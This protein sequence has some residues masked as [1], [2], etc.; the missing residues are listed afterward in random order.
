MALVPST[1]KTALIAIFVPSMTDDTFSSGLAS[2]INTFCGTGQI[3]ASSI[4]G[5][6]SAGA[7][8]GTGTGT[9]VVNIASSDIKDLCDAMKSNPHQNPDGSWDPGLGE[10]DDYLAEQLAAI[11]DDACTN[12]QFTVLISGSAV[13]G[14][15]TT[16]FTNVPGDVEW[17]GDASSLESTILNSM[18]DNMTD[19]DFADAVSKAVKDY[20]TGAQIT[21]KGTLALEGASGSGTMS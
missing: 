21:V 20:L 19:A 8:T 12:A 3:S 17:S 11:I 4:M 1:L 14:Q 5:T 15:V 16:P 10:G 2:S 13:A 6:V 18:T 9:M 7:F